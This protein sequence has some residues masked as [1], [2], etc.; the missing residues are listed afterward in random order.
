MPPSTKEEREQ[1]AAHKV[2]SIPE[3]TYGGQLQ[4]K[5]IQGHK[6]EGQIKIKYKETPGEARR[7]RGGASQAH[8]PTASPISPMGRLIRAP[9]CRRA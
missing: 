6:A 9:R 8:R 1:L 4:N 5:S 2:N 7:R 3:P